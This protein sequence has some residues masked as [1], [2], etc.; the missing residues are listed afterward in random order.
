MAFFGGYAPFPLRL[1]DSGALVKDLNDALNT[2]RGEGLNTTEMASTVWVENHAIARALAETWQTNERL[3]LQTDL[4][5][6]TMLDRWEGIFGIVP[7]PD[8][9]DAERRAVLA[10]RQGR[11][12]T[13]TTIQRIEDLL[14]TLMPE[15][16]TQLIVAT[17]QSLGTRKAY[18]GE[19][20]IDADQPSAP[21][22]VLTGT[23]TEAVTVEVLI[24]TGGPFASFSPQVA[25]TT[26]SAG[27][28]VIDTVVVPSQTLGTTGLT[29]T[30]PVS[31]W[32][33]GT[34][35]FGYA[36]PQGVWSTACDI[37]VLAE[38]PS[39]MTD[40]AYFD[41]VTRIYAIV[42]AILPA[43]AR[44]HVARDGSRAGAFVLGE[45]QN[46]NNQRLA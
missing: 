8:A 32:T 30:F 29:L 44:V 25:F 15:I 26:A 34:Y 22:L 36:F 27:R 28:T 18:P 19:W 10:E 43:W 5:K 40:A 2:G 31:T 3:G 46:L 1:G 7:A 45:A 4:S 38:K 33:T 37:T 16:P 9:T 21:T 20:T 6:T 24:V 35:Y 11:A 13:P 23:V 42:D 14:A 17:N 39:S 41:A 12:G